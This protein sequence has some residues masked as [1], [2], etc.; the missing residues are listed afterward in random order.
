M[1]R[2][3]G[4]IPGLFLWVGAA[5]AS[6]PQGTVVRETWEAAYLQNNK[7][8]FVHTTVREVTRPGEKRLVT[9]IELNLTV[10]R[11]QEKVQLRMETGTEETASGK[12]TAVSMRQFLGKEQQLYMR[13]TVQGDQLHV[14]VEGGR[15]LDKKIPWNDTV[16][17]LGRQ[18]QLFRERQVKP[19]DRFSYLTYEPTIT[20][21]VTNRVTV[22]EYEDVASP[23]TPKPQRL[24]R[25][26]TVADKIAGVQLPPL[27][28]W[29][30]AERTPVRSQVDMPG[31]GMLTLYRATPQ[32]AR[33]AAGPGAPSLDIGISQLI[34]I[35]QRIPR[36]YDTETAVYR[37][38]I[39][40]DDDAATT[41][42]RDDRQE[43][44]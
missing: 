14:K 39:K 23:L 34:R 31:L 22:K 19:G 7:A 8:G 38:T 35:N 33:D 2:Q 40:G 26:E 13:G 10:K 4:W 27:I 43:V 28:L 17:G 36:P 29:L 21:V 12:V 18:D 42:A 41:F 37:I 24:L 44:K 15:R 11:F 9:V 30:D 25:V 6:E 5:G 32:Q 1:H 3:W 16:I 20:A